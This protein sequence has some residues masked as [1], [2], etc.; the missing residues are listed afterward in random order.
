MRKNLRIKV[1]EALSSVLPI[2]AIVLILIFTLVPMDSGTTGLFLVGALLLILG[3]GLFSLGAE[4]SMIPIG[5]YLGA[6]V[7]K[8]RKLKFMVVVAF[9]IG[10]LITIAEP[11]LQVLSSQV[12]FIPKEILIGSIALGVGIMLM[13]SVLRIVFKIPLNRLL[14]ISYS[15]IFLL[16]IL[17][18]AEFI[19]AAFDAGGVTTGPI[20]V[21]FI[22]AFGVGI[23][24]VRSG[25][26]SEEDSFGLVGLCTTGPVLAMM[27]LGIIYPSDQM[28]A[29]TNVVANPATTHDITSLFLHAFPTYIIEVLVALSPIIL[30]FLFFQFRYLKLP[31]RELLRIA[32]GLVYTF[33]GLVLFLTGVNVGF[34]PAGSALGESLGASFSWILIPLGAVM[35]YFI[36]GAEPAVPVLIDQVEDVTGGAISR[37][38]MQLSLS[39]GVSASVALSMLRIVA[40][41]SIWWVLVPGYAVALTLS[42]FVPKVFTGIAYDAGAV[43]TGPM[44]AAFLLP[45]AMGACAALGGNILLDAFGIVAVITMTPIITV[46]VMG[47]VFAIKTRKLQE[48]QQ[49]MEKTMEDE[50]DEIIDL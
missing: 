31:K 43:A 28:V 15:L 39:I 12:P 22:L 23:A 36:V 50:T 7:S 41:F 35:G 42:F 9:L 40:G 24:S 38:S 47:L 44:A 16:G 13:F 2:T 37:R 1:N 27:I 48:A 14:L 26:S 25:K 21:P 20:T 34:L 49:Q 8:S 29:A 5:T 30:L 3:M 32:I 33:F 11:D 46:Q 19:P 10:V 17:A 4:M 18:S 45:F 6:Q